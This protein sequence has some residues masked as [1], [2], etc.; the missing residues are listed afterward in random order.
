MHLVLLPVG[1]PLLP[2]D[3]GPVRGVEVPLDAR[4]VRA[5]ELLSPRLLQGLRSRELLACSGPLLPAPLLPRLPLP[6][7]HCT[8][9]EVVSQE[10]L[11]RSAPVR[12][13]PVLPGIRPEKLGRIVEPG[14]SA[15]ALAPLPAR[16]QA[17]ESVVDVTHLG[18]CLPAS[19]RG[20][21]DRSL[22]GRIV[23][24][25]LGACALAPLSARGQAVESVV[26]VTHLGRCLPASGRGV[27][28]RGLLTAIGLVAF[29][30][31]RC[32][33]EIGRGPRT[34]TSL[35]VT[36]RGL[37]TATSLGGSV[38]VPLLVGEVAVTG[39]GHAI[40][41]AALMTVWSLLSSD[42]SQSKDRSRRAR[43]E[44]LEGV[45]TFAV[46]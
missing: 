37:L 33:G 26:D 18:R 14:L 24:P 27:I 3:L 41:L 17:V 36:G 16:G 13:P 42:R 1:L 11:R 25:G 40:P 45:E 10:S 23:E 12:D 35:G 20:V 38:R 7:H 21:I 5:S 44:L 32:F 2:F 19:G 9:C 46:S 34:A 29:A 28:D 8:L 15:C 39:L 43:R 30:L 4:P 22:L 6:A 31:A